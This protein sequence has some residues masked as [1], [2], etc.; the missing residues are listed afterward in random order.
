MQDITQPSPLHAQITAQ[1]GG[2]V[3]GK[4]TA[5]RY[6]ADSEVATRGVDLLNS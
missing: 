4:R 2:G 5:T 6:L 3:S 1:P